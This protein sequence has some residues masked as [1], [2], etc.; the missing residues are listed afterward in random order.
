MDHI[1]R[2][3][4]D[5]DAL[6]R[7]ER[8]A[9][10]GASDAEGRPTTLNWRRVA[11]WAA[12]VGA[13]AV[14]VHPRRE[15]I[16]G[17][18][19]YRSIEDVPGRVDV[20]IVLIGDVDSV[21]PGIAAK[22]VG[23]VVLFAAGYAETGAAGA[24]RQAEL[25]RSLRAAG[26]RALG[27]NTNLNLFEEFRTDLPGRPIALITQ[28]GHQ[29]RPVFQGQELGIR[30]S[31]WAPTGNEADLNAAD[32]VDYFAHEEDTGAIALYLEGFADG[33]AFRR[34]ARVA[35]RRGV[36]LVAVKVGRTE[37]GRSWAM[38]HTGHL[39]GA[40]DVASAVMRQYGIARV[41]GLDELL[42]TAA[43]FARAGDPPHAGVC[44]Y[45]ISG[46]TSAHMADL[47]G[48]AGLDLPELSPETV[49]QLR[50]WIPD[51]LRVS[52]PVDNGGHPVGDWRGRRIL[53]TILA[54]PAVGI[55][56]VPITGAFP[57]MSDTLVA[58]LVAVAE[59]T[60]KPI[61][62]VWGSPSGTEDAYRRVLLGSR[63][64]VFR[65]FGNCVAAIRA[66]ADHLEFRERAHELPVIPDPP[67][68]PA[69]G[70]QLTELDAKTLLAEH[71]VPVSR[72]ALCAD[73]DE[74]ARAIERHD[75]PVVLK[76]VVD[77]LAHKSDLG[78]V[79][80]GIS[81]A[82][83]GRAVVADFERILA[84]LPGRELAGVLVSEQVHGGVEMVVGIAPDPVF[85]PTVMLGVGG[86]AVE[87]YRDVSF[88]VPPFDRPE[89]HRMIAELTGSALLTGFRGSP[90]VD[91]EPLVDVVM[92][93]QRLAAD[94]VV[95][96][97]DINP[98][99]VLPDR[100]VAVD[101]L[102]SIPDSHENAGAV[103]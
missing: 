5:L 6:F 35:A 70:R 96:E 95:T 78:L 3:S 18:P 11:A 8:V 74:V 1:D 12:R 55:L 61:C 54:D 23:F 57:P 100:V 89:V 43:L 32:F 83:E 80:L 29:G 10:I 60:D 22:G 14:P 17:V 26:V 99:I 50:E 25:V 58:D 2:A 63:L 39:A 91:L 84:D 85:G 28:S 101:A 49:A 30:F 75:G 24:Q 53:E 68:M 87:L 62:V 65:T 9:V 59:T 90:P 64:P 71:G 45:A 73:A 69:A 46:G 21:L 76:A 36:P 44:V 93:V 97:L 15:V 42:D 20:A 19:A 27:P 51:Y 37:L 16:D 103:A 7:P 88:R 102:A 41:D 66:L 67:R 40:D 98:L 47:L 82:A 72:D 56:V 86:V 31:H 52:N 77:G 4:V 34:A 81:E 33:T 92:A 38:S 94:G 48:S 79:R 13:E